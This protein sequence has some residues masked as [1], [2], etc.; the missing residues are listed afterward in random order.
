MELELL[1]FRI[2]IKYFLWKNQN[3]NLLMN[4]LMKYIILE[5]YKR[6]RKISVVNLIGLK[7]IIGDDNIE[8]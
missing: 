4:I 2:T 8:G 3:I 1:E 6:F 7:K 5:W